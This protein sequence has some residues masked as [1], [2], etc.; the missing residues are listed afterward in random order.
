MGFLRFYFMSKFI[1][2]SYNHIFLHFSDLL[3][4]YLSLFKEVYWLA[5]LLLPYNLIWII[6]NSCRAIIV[7]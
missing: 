3:D 1:I 5:F 7:I 2:R 6:L 4:L